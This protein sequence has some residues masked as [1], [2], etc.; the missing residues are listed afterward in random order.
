MPVNPFAIETISQNQATEPT[1]VTQAASVDVQLIRTRLLNALGCPTRIMMLETTIA[2]LM[3]GH[4]SVGFGLEPLAEFLGYDSRKSVSRLLKES[5]E[6]QR[7]ANVSFCKVIRGER[8]VRRV[9]QFICN[10]LNTAAFF[11][12]SQLESNPDYT[13]PTLAQI[14]MY[15][16]GAIQRFLRQ[17][18]T[19]AYKP[20]S[21]TAKTPPG[22]KR[23]RRYGPAAA[24][25]SVISW[26]I[27]EQVPTSLS[28]LGLKFF[29]VDAKAKKP[30]IWKY[31]Q[32][33]STNPAVLSNWK[34]RNHETDWA[35]L[36]GEKMASG[37]CHAVI[38]LDRHG[39]KF[40]NG[41]KTLA[42]REKELGT[43]P[44]TFT[45]KTP[46][47]GEHRYF[48]SKI[49]LPTWSGELGPG[50]DCKG[51]GSGFVVA[52]GSAGYTVIKDLPIATLPEQWQDALNILPK[53]RRRIPVGERHA[54]LR[55]VSYAM[56]CQNKTIDEIRATLYERLHF[57]CESGGRTLTERE[58]L[59]LAKSAK[60]K[61]DAAAVRTLNTTVA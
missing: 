46:R 23:K 49:G 19:T 42:L 43:L 54:Y 44:E 9:H 59:Q 37:D 50:L 16:E 32:A 28:G 1:H 36:T 56:A 8:N 13:T 11:V 6:W 15:A 39:E 14:D 30:R 60:R 48:R 31:R 22:P 7:A 4:E 33:A 52:P 20:A 29:P 55:R 24:G 12:L 27:F 10:R 57:N 18:L 38:D 40:G 53:A 2:S 21:S 61:T 25:G 45:V 41:F 5:A 17:P 3:F 58:L 26:D 51:T 35:I 34:R 47:D